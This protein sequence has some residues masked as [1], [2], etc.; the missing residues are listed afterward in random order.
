MSKQFIKKEGLQLLNGGYLSNK[1]GNPVFN[2]AFVDAQRNAEYVITFA[3]KAK[4]KDF[5][6]KQADS[7]DALKKEVLEA[8]GANK[9]T[10]FIKKPEAV[11]RPTHDKLQSE[12]LEFIKFQEKSNDVEKIN[13]FLQQF[14]VINEFEEFGLFF[15]EDIVKLNKIY[16]MKEIIA[17]VTETIALLG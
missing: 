1:E 15:E 6:G 13:N 12:A 5:V 14:E 9:K 3:A 8:L 7:L 4:G 2:Q 11:K 16:T 17:A 10:V